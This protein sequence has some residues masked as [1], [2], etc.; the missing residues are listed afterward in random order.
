MRLRPEIAVVTNVE[1]D[2]H[3]TFGFAAEVEALFDGW[4]AEVPQV[5][6]GGTLEPVRSSWRCRA[7]TTGGTPPRRSRRSSSPA[8]RAAEAEP[9]L[10]RF[11]GAGRRFE[12]VGEAG[13][14]TIVDDYGHHPTE[15]AATIAAAR[16]RTPG[17]GAR[18]LPA[19]PLL[20]H[21]APR[22]RARRRRSPA[23]TSS[24]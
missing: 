13:G 17:S 12:L 24:A 11:R 4:L 18:P 5:V 2:H 1:L 20:A 9:V 22:A 7:S 15:I 6:R 21:A 23:P 10:A 14:V 16:E 19:A 8:S 3:A